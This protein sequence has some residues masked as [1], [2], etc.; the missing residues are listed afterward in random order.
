MENKNIN[1]VMDSELAGVIGEAGISEETYNEIVDELNKAFEMPI[2]KLI[3]D[4]ILIAE[5][6]LHISDR[7][8]EAIKNP[9]ANKKLVE[10]LVGYFNAKIEVAKVENS[11]DA[12]ELRAFANGLD[13]FV[14]NVH[15]AET[16]Y[17]QKELE[18]WLNGKIK[19]MSHDD[20]VAWAKHR[21]LIES[22]KAY[23]DLMATSNQPSA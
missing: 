1:W 11:E 21:S 22:I 19:T 9:E 4:S 23:K 7:L 10:D 17:N 2:V 5:K 20:L 15:Y 16:S 3:F 18:I 8:P 6:Q 13:S 14:R 12:E